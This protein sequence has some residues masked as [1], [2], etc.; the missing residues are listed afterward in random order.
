MTFGKYKGQPV[1]AILQDRQYCEWILQQPWFVEKFPQ[2]HTVIINNHGEPAET[3]EHNQLQ[4]MFVDLEFRR[5]YLDYVYGIKPREGSGIE[6]QFE[7]CAADVLMFIGDGQWLEKSFYVE[8]KP[9]VGDDYPK[10]LREMDVVRERLKL[11]Y[12]N[13]C[14]VDAKTSLLIGDGGYT[15]SVP[16]EVMREIFASRKIAVIF[17]EDLMPVVESLRLT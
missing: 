4:A 5:R 3:P 10:I 13:H 7:Y 2:I 14:Q 6:V 8:C 17:L 11:K 1:E 9:T 12:H 15:G 16:Y